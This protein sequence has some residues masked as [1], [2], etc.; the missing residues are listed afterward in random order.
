VDVISPEM[1]AAIE[2]SFFGPHWVALGRQLDALF[3][4]GEAAAIE[5]ARSEV[6]HTLQ[7]VFGSLGL[8][9]RRAE[10]GGVWLAPGVA[11]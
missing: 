8:Q 6:Q 11:G 1:A 9:L 4:A 7:A 3:H 5:A 2:A 10:D